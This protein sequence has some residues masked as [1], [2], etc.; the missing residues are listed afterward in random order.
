MVPSRAPGS[1]LYV[2]SGAAARGLVVCEGHP[3]PAPRPRLLDRV[4]ARSV[5]ATTADAPR[6]PTSRGRAGTS[7]F[8]ASGTRSRWAAPK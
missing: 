7:F 5:P 1:M 6:R 8:T 2:V 4:R 3:P